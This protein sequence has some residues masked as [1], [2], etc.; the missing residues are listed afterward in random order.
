MSAVRRERAL[1]AAV[2]AGSAAGHALVF[3]L[4][5]LNVPQVRERFV[6]EAEQA[7]IIDL[8]RPPPPPLPPPPSRRCPWRRSPDR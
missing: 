4:I 3:A 7:M 5:G 8:F 1:K 6:E 2:L